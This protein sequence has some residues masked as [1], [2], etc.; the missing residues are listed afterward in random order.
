MR[1]NADMRVVMVSK[2]LVVGA[3]Q[4]KAEEIAQLG[5]D[6]T[7]LIPPHW[8]DRRGQQRAERQHTLGYQLKIVPLRFNGRFHWHYYPTLSRELHEIRPDV[9]HMD[10][11]PYNLATWLG[12]RAAQRAGVASLFF[13]WQNLYRAYPPPFRWFEQANY[14]AASLAI[15]GNHSAV[16]VLHR[17]GYR[18][19]TAVIPQ[20]GVDPAIFHPDTAAAQ[21]SAAR[22]ETVHIGYAGG[23][24]PEKGIDLLLRA[25]AQLHGHWHLHLAGTGAEEDA[26]R[27]LIR[28][29]GCDERVSFHGKVGS[30]Q[31]PAFY[32]KIDVF[33]LPS[34]TTPTWKEQFGRVLIEAM[35]SG[36][37]VVGSTSGEIPH[38]IGPAGVIFAENNIHELRDCLQRLLDSPEERHRLGQTGRERVLAHY[39]MNH[40]AQETVNLYRALTSAPS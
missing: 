22:T 23:L 33:V 36:V 19:R 21:R 17:K 14:Q 34:R 29:L 8:R 1:Y 35:A 28:D 6:L 26:L 18:G 15:A 12:L 10:E 30:T 39:T 9:L 7:V 13:T 31:M 4:R 25:C 2:A 32:R 20:F 11:E 16:D 38:V 40:V 37:A 3:Y 24:L 27:R 5:V